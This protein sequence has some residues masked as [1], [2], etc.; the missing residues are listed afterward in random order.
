MHVVFASDVIRHDTY[1]AVAAQVSS[2]V[3]A[4]GLTL[5][6]NNAGLFPPETCGDLICTERMAET[7]LVNT[8]S[9]LVL[10]KTLLPL[11]QAAAAAAPS[12]KYS[13]NM[14]VVILMSSDSGS[15]ASQNESDYAAFNAIG[16]RF[17]PAYCCSKVE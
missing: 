10:T 7:Y 6:I 9:P 2:I 15:I 12:E 8:I 14:P 3:G 5:L 1:E 13:L 16:M 17:I 4:D 11:L